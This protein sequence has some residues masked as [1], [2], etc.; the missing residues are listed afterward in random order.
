MED[1]DETI[2]YLEEG[3]YKVLS[4]KQWDEI[5]ASLNQIYEGRNTIE[6]ILND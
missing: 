6:H 3:G 5:N 4:S 2:E 1:I